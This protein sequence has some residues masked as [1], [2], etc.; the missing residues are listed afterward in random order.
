[1]SDRA[2]FRGD[3]GEQAIARELAALDAFRYTAFHGI[4]APARDGSTQIDHIVVSTFGIFVIETKNYGG[5][6]FGKPDQKNWVQCLGPKKTRFSNPVWQNRGHVSALAKHLALPAECF[7]NL[8]VFAD[9]NCWFPR[10]RHPD[11]LLIHELRSRIGDFTG[12]LLSPSDVEQAI[13][14]LVELRDNPI[15]TLEEHVSALRERLGESVVP[16]ISDARSYR[17]LTPA[18][19]GKNFLAGALFIVIIGVL[20]FGGVGWVANFITETMKRSLPPPPVAI[21]TPVPFLTPQITASPPVISFATPTPPPK[22]ITLAPPP[23]KP[24]TIANVPETPIGVRAI[25]AEVLPDDGSERFRVVP[26]ESSAT[27]AAP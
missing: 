17:P 27:N 22:P 8:V 7:H 20:L 19:S 25:H 10:E 9:G 15:T 21:H 4:F 12:E 1:M 11:V 16:P 18:P 13:S 26:L 23:K 5:M 6:I 3:A 2:I 14:T 24:T